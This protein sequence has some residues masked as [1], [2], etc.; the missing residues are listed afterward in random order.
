MDRK[1]NR[2]HFYAI[3]F[4]NHGEPEHCMVG[5]RMPTI[6]EAKFFL[7]PL[8]CDWGYGNVAKVEEISKETAFENFNISNKGE[9]SY[10]KFAVFGKGLH[11]RMQRAY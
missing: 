6:E 7:E 5:Y 11:W 8:M 4:D 1:Y 2:K 3:T 9:D 10:H